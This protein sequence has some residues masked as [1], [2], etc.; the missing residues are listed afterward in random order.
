MRAPAFSVVIPVHNGA[1]TI[2]RAIESVLAQS[3]PASELI[4]VDDG[5]TD[6]TPRVVAEFGAAV[7][8]L[9]QANAGVSAARNNGVRQAK[10]DWLAFLD[11]DDWYY[12]ERL[13]WHAEWIARDSDLDFLTG[14][15]DYRRPDGSLISRSMEN[16]E[17][18]TRLL[19]KANGAREVIMDAD[20]MEAFV[21]NH[22]GDTHTLSVPRD[23]F[24]R[25]GGYPLAQAVCE[26][27]HFLIRLCAISKRVGVICE[28]MGVYL[29]RPDSATR[30]DVVRSQ[31]L[32][33]EALRP[34]M[35]QLESAPP[36]I[37]R[38]G[39]ARLRRA[40]LN[41]AYALLRQREGGKA[42]AA[43]LASLT[44]NPSLAAFRDV[45]SVAWGALRGGG[46]L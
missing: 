15:Y 20:Q 10:G 32:T 17:S 26:D 16:T 1:G 6:E 29:I 35:T 33:V 27:V 42:L 4:V 24:M 34:L 28:P 14:D 45:A 8:Y 37:K 5:S 40:R 36:A 31:R 30:T 38:G 46:P 41:L 12:P 13:R 22:F 2:A 7:V 3:Y 43:V 19:L 11:A 25:L 9:R 39:R 23:T 21:E 18:G 44:E